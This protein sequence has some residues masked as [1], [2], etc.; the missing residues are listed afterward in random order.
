MYSYFQFETKWKKRK[1]GGSARK[2]KKKLRNKYPK[3]PLL[4]PDDKEIQ[5]PYPELIRETPNPSDGFSFSP[6]TR[7]ALAYL[8]TKS[9]VKSD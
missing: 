2:K 8:V 5:E 6:K 1:D 4:A 3:A 9:K 7:Q